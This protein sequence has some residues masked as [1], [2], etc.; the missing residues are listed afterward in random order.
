[1]KK[2]NI[3][4]L[5]TCAAILALFAIAFIDAKHK[6][7]ASIIEYTSVSVDAF[8]HIVLENSEKTN[9]IQD[10]SNYKLSFQIENDSSALDKYYRLANDTLYLTSDKPVKIYGKGISSICCLKGNKN[11]Y[12][13]DI[14]TDSLQ[15]TSAGGHISINGEKTEIEKLSLMSANTDFSV[16]IFVPVEELDINITN[17]TINIHNGKYNNVDIVAQENSSVNFNTSLRTENSTVKKDDTSS[18][19]LR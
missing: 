5:I 18:V 11:L 10:S 19:F 17:S 9:F 4:L 8:T 1:M 3:I 14:K 12:I 16:S 6:A 15:I 13:S 2:S 7:K